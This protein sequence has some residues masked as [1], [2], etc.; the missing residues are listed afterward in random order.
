MSEI[1][2]LIKIRMFLRCLEMSSE[3]LST[4]YRKISCTSRVQ[5]NLDPVRNIITVHIA[6]DKAICSW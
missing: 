1:N 2:E 4:P 3:A 5:S 6:C